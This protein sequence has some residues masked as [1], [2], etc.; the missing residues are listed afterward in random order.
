VTDYGA[1]Q[2]PPRTA[3]DAA[4]ADTAAIEACISDAITKNKTVWLPPGVYYHDRQ[5]RLDGVKLR[6][7]GMWHTALIG[8]ANGSVRDYGFRLA[9]DGAEVR[10]LFIENAIVDRRGSGAKAI[11]TTPADAATNWRVE[12]VWIT[13]SHVGFWMSGAND[14]LVRNN[15]IRF[16][17]ADSLTLNRGSSRNLVEHNHIRGS[18]DDGIA[19]LSETAGGTHK[20][21]NAAPP[22]TGNTFRRNTIIANW[23]GHNADMAGGTG[24]VFENNYLADNSAMGCLTINHPM[25]YPMRDLTDSII[26]GN[27]IVRGGG[28]IT[29]QLRGAMWIYT[30]KASARDIL[31]EDNHIIDSP[32]RGIHL[33][34]PAPQEIR[35]VRNRID[36]P[37][38]EGVYI[39]KTVTG[40][41][42]FDGNSVTGATSTP[43]RNASPNGTVNSSGNNWQE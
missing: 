24:H 16:T 13:H 7:A 21:I 40:T 35:F 28:R 22:S 37:G 4:R 18:G 39:E 31:V 3:A 2:S 42:L 19:T 20:N 43:F 1:G 29:G 26:R 14:G 23:W 10:D 33:A 41:L 17:Y 25:P 30:G 36:N 9:G 8:I 38:A 27:V 34:G 6:G 12:N 5:L 11:S 32:Y 15:R